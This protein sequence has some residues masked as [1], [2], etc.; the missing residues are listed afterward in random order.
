MNENLLSCVAACP[1]E[2]KITAFSGSVSFSQL[3][4]Q[5]TSKLLGSQANMI[6][7]DYA[8]ALELYYRLNYNNPFMDQL[9]ALSRLTQSSMGQLK[10]S[11]YL[12]TKMSSG[13]DL[14]DDGVGEDMANLQKVLLSFQQYYNNTFKP[15]RFQAKKYITESFNC[16]NNLDFVLRSEPTS[17][18]NFSVA[19]WA[20]TK[21]NSLFSACIVDTDL[22]V[23]YLTEAI[24]LESRT[25]KPYVPDQ[26]YKSPPYDY[27]ELYPYFDY[28]CKNSYEVVSETLKEFAPILNLASR[29]VS[30]WLQK[31]IESID[32]NT[33]RFTHS[34]SNTPITN[35]FTTSSQGIMTNENFS[36][37]PDT[38]SPNTVY[39][40]EIF[41]ADT[42]GSDEYF[43]GFWT[44]L[45]CESCDQY[46]NET[47]SNLV[48]SLT[49][50]ACFTASQC[51]TVYESSLFD[52]I[53]SSLLS[54]KSTPT[55]SPSD[56]LKT[57]LLSMTAQVTN[58]EENIHFYIVGS[59]SGKILSTLAENI[60][61][62]MSL[63]LSI[64]EDEMTVLLRGWE[65]DVTSWS[66]SI[67]SQYTSVCKN[68]Y[69]LSRFLYTS[70]QLSSGVAGLKMWQ[71][72]RI[73]YKP[74]ASIAFSVTDS[75][76][77]IKGIQKSF[78]SFIGGTGE[79]TVQDTMS[80]IS[81]DLVNQLHQ[82]A[83]QVK[84]LNNYWSNEQS[85]VIGLLNDFN[86]HLKVDDVFVK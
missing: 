75:T 39:S 85:F 30:L 31:N 63:N 47:W 26:F 67:I 44:L 33:G 9:M 79:K 32:I 59:S 10:D 28:A 49:S 62:N 25:G 73:V 70:T 55:F 40:T 2:C 48:A 19:Y 72:P 74:V 16:L 36:N 83:L 82:I 66:A 8:D 15:S 1:V 61:N 45:E 17:F 29:K 14:F 11:L 80:A 46:L 6:E 51:L 4:S 5:A 34:E 35:F 86:N 21:L 20:Y 23:T 54:L 77:T 7:V 37:L 52:A 38:S 18:T 78:Q 27:I 24:N 81:T 13:L 57:S 22:A 12:L 65:N 58:L 42:E 69:E 60:L 3:S 53:A 56:R 50:S 71:Q 68:L 41:H 43:S 84:M 76:G 64:I